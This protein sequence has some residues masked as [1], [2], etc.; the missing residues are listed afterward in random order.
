VSTLGVC[1]Q[2][3]STFQLAIAPPLLILFA[4]PQVIYNAFPVQ[5]FLFE[6]NNKMPITYFFKI[7]IDNSNLKVTLFCSGLVSPP[8]QVILYNNVTSLSLPVLTNIGET[9]PNKVH[10]LLPAN[11]TVGE[12]YIRVCCFLHAIFAYFM[13]FVGKSL[14]VLLKN[15]FTEFVSF[16]FCLSILI[17]IETIEGCVTSLVNP[18]LI[19]AQLTIN[20]E[21]INPAYVWTAVSTDVTIKGTA[22]KQQLNCSLYFLIKLKVR[23]LKLEMNETFFFFLQLFQLEQRLCHI[24]VCTSLHAT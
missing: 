10:V 19:T 11:L 12:W 17:Q 1:A 13:N 4:D 9:N 21:L 2:A 24:L 3:N 8:A 18:L 16:G 6:K 20:L 22:S 7:N 14:S 5:V 15:G 23:K